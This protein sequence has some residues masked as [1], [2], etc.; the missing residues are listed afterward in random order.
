MTYLQSNRRKVKLKNFFSGR[1]VYMWPVF[2]N[3]D[4]ANLLWFDPYSNRDPG[5]IVTR[6]HL[7]CSSIVFDIASSLQ[8]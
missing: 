2:D 4:E 7:S 1:A 8:P 6:R 3:G 5:D